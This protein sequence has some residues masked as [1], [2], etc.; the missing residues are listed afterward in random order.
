[1][2]ITSF[3]PYL[4]MVAMVIAIIVALAV[5]GVIGWG[6]FKYY[7][8][9]LTSLK[10]LWEW[11]FNW[12]N[13][14]WLVNIGFMSF[15]A[16]HAAPFYNAVAIDM[17]GLSTLGPYVGV[18]AAIMLDAIVIVFQSSRRKAAYKHDD[19]RKRLFTFWIFLCCGLNTAANLYTNFL[20]FDYTKYK[21]LG[22]L[23][24]DFAP[25]LLSVMPIFIMGL[26]N[27]M[28][29]MSNVDKALEGE[30]VETYRTHLKTRLSMMQATTKFQRDEAE[31]VK[32]LIEA[33][34][35]RKANARLRRGLDPNAPHRVFLL[36][37]LLSK[38]STPEKV[39]QGFTEQ[40]TTIQR[41]AAEAQAALFHQ[42]QALVKNYDQRLLEMQ[43]RFQQAQKEASEAQSLQVGSL[44]QTIEE[45]AQAVAE[46]QARSAQRSATKQ[47]M[48]MLNRTNTEEF[49][50]TQQEASSPAYYVDCGFRKSETLYTWKMDD[51]E[52]NFYTHLYAAG[53]WGLGANDTGKNKIRQFCEKYPEYWVQGQDGNHTNFILVSAK[54]AVRTYFH[55][56]EEKPTRKKVT[57]AVS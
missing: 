33:N 9:V 45:L 7:Q 6:L 47:S 24:L 34:Q 49:L 36:W 57:E 12:S 11:I 18:L 22:D 29:E 27:A 43:A 50:P 54:D 41:Q 31:E 25:A 52:L 44:T 16:I 38:V 46:M 3:T 39:I 56:P 53:I 1:M 19:D 35:L 10:K 42:Q 5:L 37:A 17:S 4:P 30:D 26:S 48:H 8:K 15:S 51:T 14:F 21:S 32:K 13:F 55:L 23:A 40:L 20:D 28:E 2:N